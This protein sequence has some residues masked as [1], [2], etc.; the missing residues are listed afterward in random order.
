MMASASLRV[1]SNP[2]DSNPFAAIDSGR[3]SEAQIAIDKIQHKKPLTFI[4]AAELA[5][6]FGRLSDAEAA[7]KEAGTVSGDIWL[8]SRFALAE[9]ELLFARQ[10]L[11]AAK[12]RFNAAFHF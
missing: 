1:E 12:K 8:A 10:Q 7:L 11:S 5:L 4:A 2:V 3:F 9:G 6:Y